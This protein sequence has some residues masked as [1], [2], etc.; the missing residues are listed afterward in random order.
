MMNNNG[1]LTLED[2]LLL[3]SQLSKRKF[4]RILLV[5]SFYRFFLILLLDVVIYVLFALSDLY[6]DVGWLLFITSGI[7]F[8]FAG[9][10]GTVGT[11]VSLHKIKEIVFREPSPQGKE[12]KSKEEK[13]IGS[14]LIYSIVGIIF[15]ITSA[16]VF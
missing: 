2:K 15:F 6:F 11:S 3:D 13:A 12:L 7:C 16:L 8:L 10:L 4:L 1:G 14:T 5:K 9:T